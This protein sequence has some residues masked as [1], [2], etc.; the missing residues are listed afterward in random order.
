MR[1]A[2]GLRQ[3]LPPGARQLL[4]A[5]AV[6]PVETIDAALRRFVAQ[7]GNRAWAISWTQT[8]A[9]RAGRSPGSRINARHAT[10]PDPLR[11]ASP[12]V[13]IS[14]GTSRPDHQAYRASRLQLQGQPQI[15]GAKAS[16]CVPV[17]PSR[18]PARYLW[19]ANRRVTAEPYSGQSSVRKSS[20]S[21]S[22]E[23]CSRT[24]SD[25]DDVNLWVR[26]KDRGARV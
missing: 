7:T 8:R 9:T 19:L 13:A 26:K 2:Q 18:A 22:Q 11:R 10:F 24:R 3:A 4:R 25:E 6:G 12:V 21:R 5:D 14:E 20:K 16:R 17:E 15:R 1:H 23:R